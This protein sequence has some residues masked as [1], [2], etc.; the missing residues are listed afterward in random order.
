M[1]LWIVGETGG[2]L[3]INVHNTWRWYLNNNFV[4]LHQF[5]SLF[6]LQISIELTSHKHYYSVEINEPPQSKTFLLFPTVLVQVAAAV[7]LSVDRL[8]LTN[9]KIKNIAIPDRKRYRLS[10][11]SVEW[12]WLTLYIFSDDTHLRL[13]ST[14]YW[15]L[16]WEETLWDKTSEHLV[17]S[18][19][20]IR[21]PLSHRLKPLLAQVLHT[22][23]KYSHTQWP[24]MCVM[25]RSINRFESAHSVWY[26]HTKWRWSRALER[27]WWVIAFTSSCL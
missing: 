11:S 13:P 20:M 16:F 2:S 26:R 8:D 10:C 9:D 23:P 6:L 22:K 1:N 17:D 4:Y 24:M 14:T 12:N 27:C 25:R 3:I 19:S 21:C 15:C 18:E 7:V 5:R